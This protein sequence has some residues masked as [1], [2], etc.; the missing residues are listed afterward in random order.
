[1]HLFGKAPRLSK[2]TS[3]FD[4]TTNMGSRPKPAVLLLGV[5]GGWWEGRALK[6]ILDWPNRYVTIV[7]FYH[8]LFG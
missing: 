1:M 2:Q 7:D 4:T 3:I 5:G 8:L 6:K